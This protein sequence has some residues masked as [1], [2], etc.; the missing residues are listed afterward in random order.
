VLPGGYD[1]GFG[2]G[3][4]MRR[5]GRPFDRQSVVNNLDDPFFQGYRDGW[6]STDRQLRETV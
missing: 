2:H 4:A 6:Q 3:V 1:D 5:R